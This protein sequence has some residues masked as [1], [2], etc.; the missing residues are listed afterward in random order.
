MICGIYII[1][2]REVNTKLNII[3]KNANVI[4]YYSVQNTTLSNWMHIES[5]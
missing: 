5:M 1:K 4:E 2:R 3:N